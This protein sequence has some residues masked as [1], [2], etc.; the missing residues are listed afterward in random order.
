MSMHLIKNAFS[1]PDVPIYDNVSWIYGI[2]PPELLHTTQ[3]GL[4]KYIIKALG[5]L[6]NKGDSKRAK[7]AR[8][9]IDNL[10]HTFH[11][12]RGG[13]SDR[14]FPRSADRTSL[15]TNTLVQAA[16]RRGNI[17]VLLCVSHCQLADDYFVD[18]LKQVG[19][20]PADYFRALKLY[21]SMEDWYH[22]NN[23]IEEV[24]AARP[25]IS[26]VIQL[27]QK[28]F[29]RDKGQGWNVSKMHG[30]TKMQYY[31]TLYG[32]GINFFGG[33]GESFHKKFVKDTGHNT[34][35]RIDEFTPQVAQR[36]YETMVL[37]IAHSVHLQRESER[38]VSDPKEKTTGEVTM[39]GQFLWNS[40]G[41]QKKI[42]GCYV[43]MVLAT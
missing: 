35:L 38:Y 32:S 13:N 39:E 27:V 5:L 18:A 15:F 2:T 36:C 42:Y 25:V 8:E 29:H 23:P 22:S 43:K 10:H 31:M 37:E 16:E 6:L 41:F 4:T 14:D 11:K 9:V 24:E 1:H 34:Q 30:L 19:V 21:L 20:I 7:K 40:V 17:F 12:A 28:V 33:P 3:E 26:D